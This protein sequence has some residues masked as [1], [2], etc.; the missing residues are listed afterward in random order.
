MA[1]YVT[2][3]IQYGSTIDF[4]LEMIVVQD[5]DKY[6][7][8]GGWICNVILPSGEFKE[9]ARISISVANKREQLF[10]DGK[11]ISNSELSNYRFCFNNNDY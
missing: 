1:K 3:G 10:L 7:G 5:T 8:V 4:A 11:T 9:Q 6:L 2:L